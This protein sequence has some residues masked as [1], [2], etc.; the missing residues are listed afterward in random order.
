MIENRGFTCMIPPKKETN[1]FD[2]TFRLKFFNKE[3]VI[4]IKLNSAQ[5]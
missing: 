2:Y 5:E 3:L 4:T 1:K